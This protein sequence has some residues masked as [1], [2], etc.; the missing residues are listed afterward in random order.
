MFGVA[1]IA[2]MREP[3]PT[4]APPARGL[5]RERLTRILRRLGQR[6]LLLVVAP[7][8]SGKTA[9]LAQLAGDAEA[10]VAWHRAEGTDAPSRTFLHRL[11]RAFAPA[12]PALPTGWASADDAAAA[13]QTWTGPPP[14]LAVDEFHNLHGTEAEATLERLVLTAPLRVV[15]GARARPGFNLSRLR[16][17]GDLLEIGPDDLRFRPW[18]VERLFSE[19]LGEPLQPD[20]VAEL[21]R[22]TEGWCAALQLFHLAAGRDPLQRRRALAVVGG[23]SRPLREYLDRNVL[24]ELPPQLREFMVTTA[25]LGRLSARICDDFLER[26]TSGEILDQLERRA[27]LVPVGDRDECRYPEFVRAHLQAALEERVGDTAARELH[28]R[29]ATILEGAGA[30]SEAAHALCRAEEW[31]ALRALLARRGDQLASRSA[32]W[33]EAVPAVVSRENPWLLVAAARECRAQGRFRAA[34]ETYLRAER[35]FGAANGTGICRRE[36]RALTTWL[37]PTSD[38]ASD[39]LGRVREATIGRP[40]SALAREDELDPTEHALAAALRYL[41]AGDIR[42]ATIVLGDVVDEPGARPALVA[43]ATAAAA[44]ALLLSGDRAGAL[45]AEVAADAAH[46]LGLGWLARM[47]RASLALGGGPSDLAECRAARRAC[48]RHDDDWGAT[49]ATLIEGWGGLAAGAEATACLEQAVMGFQRLRAGVLE[50]WALAALALALARTG[51]PAAR[52]TAVRARLHARSLGVPGAQSLASAA[53]AEADP[54]AAAQYGT[55][56]TPRVKLGPVIAVTPGV[57]AVGG[58]PPP[59]VV[60]CFGGFS[61]TIQGAPVDLGP[62]R[63]RARQMLRLLALHAGRPVHREVL[64]EALWPEAGVETAARCLHVA[65]SSLRHV[66][67]PGLA[68]G[69]PSL[70]AREGEAYRLALPPDARVDLLDFERAIVEGRAARERGERDQSI[71]AYRTAIDLHHDELLPEDGPSEWLVRERDRRA[72]EAC[73]AARSVAEMLLAGGDASGAAVACERGL[74]IDRYQDELWRL[75]IASC[76]RAGEAAAAQQARRQYVHVLRDL[77]L[78]AQWRAG[79]ANTA[80]SEATSPTV[81]TSSRT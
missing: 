30:T 72:A 46:S 32:A 63:P 55:A 65:V 60:R 58:L 68:R 23:H 45:E 1:R 37:D 56:I 36:R 7:A 49:L 74:L 66:L 35:A 33:L 4:R 26:S 19:H 79:P 22:R 61:I 80:T 64:T 24:D 2:A 75:R 42:R 52:E 57:V 34:S 53:L 78:P 62:V 14:L 77:G 9:L 3:V 71:A 25:V 38:P 59:V 21:T 81:P 12:M 50:T 6:G 11:E 40:M 16:V 15:I 44:V 41:L 70:I 27:L 5:S 47:C 69:G 76:E 13:L 39:W 8:G 17:S 28:V 10:P 54:A 73:E 29:A 43:I 31:A 20:V 48:E 67:E 18:E 51:E